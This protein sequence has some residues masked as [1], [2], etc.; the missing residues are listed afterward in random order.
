MMALSTAPTDSTCSREK[1]SFVTP[2]S[3][4]VAGGF[5]SKNSS[6]WLPQVGNGQDAPFI[7]TADLPWKMNKTKRECPDMN[8]YLVL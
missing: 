8:M 3:P 1:P 6:L 4:V 7:N 2:T 5:K